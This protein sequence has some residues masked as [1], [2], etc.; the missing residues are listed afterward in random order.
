MRMQ[1]TTACAV[2]AALVAGS[3]GVLGTGS[4]AASADATAKPIVTV[5]R[6]GGLC[7]SGTRGG[8]VCR[9]EL[10]ISDTTISAAGFVSRRLRPSERTALLR[11]IR[12]LDLASIRAHPFEGTCPIA[13]DG[14]E[15]IYRFRGF[16]RPLASCEYELRRVPAVRLTER[17]LATLKPR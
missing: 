11:S 13:S 2:A 1:L 3:S 12:T 16:S 10:R 4:A 14:T 5:V 6:H 17:L 15:S 9:S 8:I 7:L